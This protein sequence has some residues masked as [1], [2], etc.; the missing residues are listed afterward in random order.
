M[1]FQALNI[2]TDFIVGMGI[3]LV[4]FYLFIYFGMCN[5]LNI[6][7][8]K[9]KVKTEEKQ[10]KKKS[11]LFQIKINIY[12]NMK[13]AFYSDLWHRESSNMAG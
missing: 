4:D 1:L 11:L 10:E 2:Q 13:S 7:Y 6:F 3:F 9:M 8:L 5:S 12:I